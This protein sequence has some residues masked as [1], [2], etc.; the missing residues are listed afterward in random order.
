MTWE[1]MDYLVCLKSWEFK[2][3]K[4]FSLSGPRGERGNDGLPG[5]PGLPGV[6]GV[7]I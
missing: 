2:V 1:W 6:Q 5:S 4:T 3:V 7:N